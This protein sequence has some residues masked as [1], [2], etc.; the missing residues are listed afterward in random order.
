MHIRWRQERPRDQT[1][2]GRLDP[3]TQ[4]CPGRCRASGHVH[5]SAAGDVKAEP[6]IP[7]GLVSD[8]PA[9]A[10]RSPEGFSRRCCRHCVAP[11]PTLQWC[12]PQCKAWGRMSEPRVVE[13]RAWFRRSGQWLVGLA[14]MAQSQ[15]A[16]AEGLQNSAHRLNPITK[17]FD[18][19][20][21]TMWGMQR[22]LE[23]NPAAPLPHGEA[24]AHHKRGGSMDS[25]PG[26]PPRRL[27]Q[28]P[29]LLNPPFHDTN[30]S[31]VSGRNMVTRQHQ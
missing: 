15:R 17:G 1:V 5:P 20:V 4:L 12:Q 28:S 3:R 31:C 29:T 26:T 2:G 22:L 9:T 21:Q 7:G 14:S 13:S 23:L 8:I 18:N 25:I 19:M 11:R 24:H 30:A 16:N 10:R 27:W 6:G